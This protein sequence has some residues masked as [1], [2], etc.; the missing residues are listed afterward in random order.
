MFAKLF[1]MCG[2]PS[3]CESNNQDWY[4]GNELTPNKEGA[5]EGDE[6][7]QHDGEINMMKRLSFIPIPVAHV[8]RDGK[9]YLLDFKDIIV[10]DIIYLY[11]K[12]SGIIPA[13]MILFETSP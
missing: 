12:V 10:G 9:R 8:L 11:A 7:K 6:Q 2:S 1:G 3:S 4:P 13:D 5:K